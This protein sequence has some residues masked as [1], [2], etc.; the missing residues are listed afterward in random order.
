MFGFSPCLPACGG[1]RDGLDVLGRFLIPAKEW[2]D[3]FTPDF[4]RPFVDRRPMDI[5][6]LRGFAGSARERDLVALQRWGR[7]PETYVDT[8]VAIVIASALGFNPG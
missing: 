2:T 6:S 4:S 1:L 5:G 7:H 8:V 3:A